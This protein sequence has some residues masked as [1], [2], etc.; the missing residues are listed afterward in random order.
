[1]NSYAMED[2]ITAFKT[3]GFVDTINAHIGADAYSYVF[4][5][6]SGYLDHALATGHLASQVNDV[7]E[8]HINPDEPGVL[9]YNTNFKTPNQVTTFYAADAYR[10]SDHDPVIVGL[11]LNGPPTVDAG[12][13][14][15]VVEGGTVTVTA[16]GN[17]PD[18]DPLTYAWDLDNN[19]SFET[20]GQSATFSAAG[21]LAPLS[22]TIRVQVS[23]GDLTATDSAT[24]NV[25][26]AFSGFF[27]PVDN[28]PTVNVANA[29]SGIPIKFA[30]GGDQGLDILAAGYPTSISFTCDAAAPTDAIESTA[31]AGDG[32]LTYDA[33]T[34]TYTYVW[35]TQK[36]WANTCRRLVVKLDDGT[37]HYADFHFV[38]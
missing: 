8:W 20:S 18:G 36:S 24:V 37:F 26:W 33:A 9:D 35:K 30:L 5:G 17:D 38:K 27:Q 28:L 4:D 10:S 23:D 32:G 19:G 2:P 22:L 1:M 3:G 7:T 21:L 14:Y 6:Q 16:T 34:G 29:G 13:P 25:I 15:A 12:G 31:S 11:I